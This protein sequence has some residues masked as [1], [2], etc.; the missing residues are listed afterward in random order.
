MAKYAIFRRALSERPFQITVLNRCI[1]RAASPLSLV[2]ATDQSRRA[3]NK[4]Q[5]NYAVWKGCIFVGMPRGN[6][7]TGVLFGTKMV[8]NARQC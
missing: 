7:G 4:K 6:S 1:F 8:E 5:K 2:A 3:T